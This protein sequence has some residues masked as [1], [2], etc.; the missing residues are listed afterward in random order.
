[1]ASRKTTPLAPRRAASRV[2]T[3][4][5]RATEAAIA[6]FRREKTPFALIGGIALGLRSAPRAT[7]D[8]DFAVALDDGAA[9]QLI[10]AFQRTG[11]EITAVLENTRNQSLATV[12]VNEPATKTLIDLLISFC[13]IE[14][15]I[16]RSATQERWHTLSLPVARSGHLVAMKLLANRKQ[17]QADIEALL[18][19]IS[20]AE[21]RRALTA[22]RHIMH[23]GLGDKRDLVHELEAL[24]S[25]PRGATPPGFAVRL[26][27]K[28]P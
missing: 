24:F 13:G 6:I 12:R 14:K 3:R 23:A 7:Q 27:P 2:A 20:S 17:D 4:L 9:E 18:L 22:V 11:F 21:R 8:V 15:E 28:R 25:V 16:V 26:P 1:M 10:H 5:E 19:D